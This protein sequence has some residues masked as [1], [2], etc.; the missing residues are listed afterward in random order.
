MNDIQSNNNYQ[1][2]NLIAQAVQN[3]AKARGQDAEIVSETEAKQRREERLKTFN[4][5][6]E[7][8]IR[9]D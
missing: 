5:N 3:G 4:I 7:N 8:S 2:D 1:R 9:L 6:F